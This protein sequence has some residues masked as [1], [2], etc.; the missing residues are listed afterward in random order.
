MACTDYLSNHK[1]QETCSP[2]NNLSPPP[3]APALADVSGH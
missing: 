1:E 3:Q 2:K